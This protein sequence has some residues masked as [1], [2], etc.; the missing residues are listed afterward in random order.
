MAFNFSH[1]KDIL[2]FSVNL[3]LF[4]FINYFSRNADSIII[5]RYMSASVLG[6]YSLAYRI[7]LFPLQSLTFVISRSLFPVLSKNQD[8]HGNLRKIYL[9][10]VFSFYSLLFR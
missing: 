6:A 10:C 7:M 3:S 4:N 5:G 2:G 1:L 8:D 9:N